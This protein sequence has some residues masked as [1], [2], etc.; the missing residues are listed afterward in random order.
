MPVKLPEDA[1]VV[2]VL[3]KVSYPGYSRDIVA[4]GFVK[5]V[6]VSQDGRVTI[7]IELPSSDASQI[8]AIEEDVRREVGNLAGVE[9]V[10]VQVT[11]QE[12]RRETPQAVPPTTQEVR[13]VSNIIAVASGKGG[14][15]KSTVAVNLAVSL[16]RQGTSTGLLDSD[17]YGP[18]VPLMM[19]IRGQPET[20]GNWIL[21][22]ENHGVRTM[23]I[24]Y[25]L[26]D[27][28]SPV[29]W[30]GP[31][32][33]KALTQFLRQVEWGNL[34]YLV[35]DLPPGTGDAQLT[36]VQSVPITG[37][38]VVT[39]PQEVALIDAKK[40]VGMFRKTGVPILGIVENMSLFSCPS[41]GHQ[42]AIFGEGGGRR[43]ADRLQVPFLGSLPLDPRV[44]EG[45]DTGVPMVA[46]HPDSPV[47]SAFA[48]VTAAVRRGVEVPSAG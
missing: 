37:A 27:E 41:C 8:P 26:P 38:V 6:K 12:P 36:L 1:Q 48:R 18:S 3:K 11:A 30:R 44:R 28:D 5:D 13:G 34:D 40:A 32:V 9:T 20:K 31:M 22:L 45:G 4:F 14:V 43:M 33:T 29:I 23:S 16:A 17:I 35:L 25:L 47:A 7:Q 19:G 42:E 24:A 15:G 39:T 2:A 10:E 21:P 46:S